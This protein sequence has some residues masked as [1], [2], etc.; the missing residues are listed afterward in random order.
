M[1]RRTGKRKGS[2]EQAATVAAEELK[3]GDMPVSQLMKL[4]GLAA[5]GE[6]RAGQGPRAVARQ[7]INPEAKVVDLTVAELLQLLAT[8]HW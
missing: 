6:A 1:A 2:P 5:P 3:V 8:G 7:L 4:L